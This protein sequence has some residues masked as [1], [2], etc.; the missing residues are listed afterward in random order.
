MLY[1]PASHTARSLRS[2]RFAPRFCPTSVA[3][4]EQMPHE[5]ISANRMMRM[6]SE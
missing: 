2:G 6:A 5:G 4:A 1:R 3:A